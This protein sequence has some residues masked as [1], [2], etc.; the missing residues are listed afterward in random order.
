[1]KSWKGLIILMIIL[2]AGNGFCQSLTVDETRTFSFYY[3]NDVVR[4]TDKNYSNAFKLA[5]ISADLDEYDELGNLIPDASTIVGE[6]FCREG[7]QRNIGISVGQNIYTPDDIDTET[8]V[9]DHRPYAG[10]TYFG[11][12]L[13]RKNRFI[14]DTVELNLGIVGPASLAEEGQRFVHEIIG[15]SIPKGWDNQLHNELGFTLTLQRTFRLVSGDAAIGWG[16]D[17]IPHAG[18]TAGTFAVYANTGAELRFGYHIPSDFGNA[19]VRPG[20][21]VSVPAADSDTPRPLHTFSIMA[22]LGAE[23]RAVA[24]NIFLDG[25]TFTDSH[26]VDKKPFV[27][28]LSAGISII[29][30]NF[31]LN[32]THVYR[33]REFEKQDEGHIFG[34]LSLSYFY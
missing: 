20:S 31:K 11:F 30:K 9:K 28:D 24:H 12:A 5:W 4:R 23:G 33:S 19:L 26:S 10:M 7:F 18:I 16:W 14:L 8:L 6:S 13:H 1:M 27:A 21:N 25:N 32:Y 3:E 34:S 15:S 17:L 22:F 2:P 29:Y